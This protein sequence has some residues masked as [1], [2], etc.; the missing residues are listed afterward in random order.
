MVTSI[1]DVLLY[2]SGAALFVWLGFSAFVSWREGEPRAAG[3]LLL[4]T[5][6][7]PVPYLAVV[8]LPGSAGATTGTVIL[9][10][11][12]FAAAFVLIP[13]GSKHRAERDTPTTRFDE[14]DVMFS[15]VRLVPGS[16]R[17]TEYYEANPENFEPD[18]KFRAEAGLLR[19]GS[20]LYEPLSFAAADASF[21]TVEELRSLV[22]GKV[23]AEQEPVEAE[24]MT[25][26]LKGWAQKLGAVSVGVTELHDYHKYTTV[27]R[28]EQYGQSVQLDHARA[29]AVTVEMAKEMIDRAPRGPTVMES[30]QQY[31]ASGA[32]AVQMALFIRSLGYPARAHIDGN[33][34][35]ICPLVARDAGLGEIGRMG[36]LM[37]PMLGPRV[38]I[39]VVTTDL[40][41]TLDQRVPEDSVI[42]FCSICLKCADACP[43]QAIST[44]ARSEFDGALRWRIDSEACFTH[45][46]KIG[47]D[48]ARCV[49]VCPYSHPDNPMHAAVRFAIRRSSIARRAALIAD[50]YVYG[51]LPP[52]VDT[53]GWMEPGRS[54]GR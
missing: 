30:A 31:L 40:P 29:I 1:L 6:L 42:D 13:T 11:T 22:D 27:G 39:A 4:L 50:D 44:E 3:R 54:S 15:R 14:R 34:R 25:R 35:V 19:K 47:T 53:D 49:S 38:R 24:T 18:E 8:L 48:C 20:T 23:A 36:L 52:P 2:G 43:S 28:G 46:C 10:L 32:I 12:L 51:R 16:K 33:Y 45:W 21:R 37:T 9:T 5:L 41:L 7:L 17:F 26:F